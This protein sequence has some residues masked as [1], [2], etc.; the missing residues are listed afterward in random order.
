MQSQT[1]TLLFD[2]RYWLS[3]LA[4]APPYPFHGAGRAAIDP[5]IFSA[6]AGELTPEEALDQAAAAVDEL[7]KELGYAK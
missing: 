2:E 7:M 1:H 4:G 5:F 6:L 3:L